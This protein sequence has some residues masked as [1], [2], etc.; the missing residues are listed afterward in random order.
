MLG[1]GTSPPFC[2]HYGKAAETAESK[3]LLAGSRGGFGVF[4]DRIEA[5]IDPEQRANVANGELSTGEPYMFASPTESLEGETPTGPLTLFVQ[6]DAGWTQAVVPNSQSPAIDGPFVCGSEGM[7]LA[8]RGPTASTAA[9]VVWSAELCPRIW[10]EGL[11]LPPPFVGLAPPSAAPGGVQPDDAQQAPPPPDA[12]KL[13]PDAPF[14]DPPRIIID[15][16]P[17]STHP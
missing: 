16:I 9:T 13:P 5:E 11:P 1:E 15:E 3:E 6:T 17:P 7:L 4:Y 2:R 14:E 12:G 8:M 10:P